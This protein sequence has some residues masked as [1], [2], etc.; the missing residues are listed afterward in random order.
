MELA[1]IFLNRTAGDEISSINREVPEPK[2]CTGK[3]CKQS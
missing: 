3:K 1:E 2:N